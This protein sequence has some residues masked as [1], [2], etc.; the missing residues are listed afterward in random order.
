MEKKI[1]HLTDEEIENLTIEVLNQ[2][3]ENTKHKINSNK[4]AKLKKTFA[5]VDYLERER[6]NR[7]TEKV[8][9]S[10]LTEEE[11]QKLHQQYTETAKNNFHDHNE[12]RARLQ[13]LAKFYVLQ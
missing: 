6:R 7:M 4:E 11:E 2:H 8:Q 10:I 3:L 1:E 12:H 5:N 13:N 9:A